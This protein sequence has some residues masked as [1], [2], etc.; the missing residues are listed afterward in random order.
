MPETQS[1]TNREVLEGS[2]FSVLL[3]SIIRV[4]SRFLSFIRV[5]LRSPAVVFLCVLCLFAAIPI[6]LFFAPLRPWPT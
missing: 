1:K 6:C 4:H 3:W 2:V 5:N